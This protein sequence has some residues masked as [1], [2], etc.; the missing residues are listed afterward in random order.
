[1]SEVVAG[2]D[3]GSPEACVASWGVLYLGKGLPQD[4]VMAQ[5]GSQTDT[6]STAYHC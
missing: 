1:M 5:N 6:E 2:G 3:R 4:G